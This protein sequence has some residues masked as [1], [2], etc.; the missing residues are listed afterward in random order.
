MTHLSRK[1]IEILR[2]PYLHR[3]LARKPRRR[4]LP[5]DGKNFLFILLN[6]IGD[7]IMA[8]P[9]WRML[10]SIRPQAKIELLC[11]RQIAALFNQDEALDAVHYFEADPD[12]WWSPR[13][14]H[15]IEAL[16]RKQNYEVILDFTESPL[17]ALA[18]ARNTAP[19]SI[20]F[21]RLCDRTSNLSRAYDC[22]VPYTDSEHIRDMM[23]HLASPWI[24]R[25]GISRPNPSLSVAEEVLDRATSALQD[26]SLRAGRFIVFHPGAKWSPKRWP[27]AHWSRLIRR[28]RD[29]TSWPLLLLGGKEDMP[30]VNDILQNSGDLPFPSLLG[31]TLSS[32]AAIIKLASLCVCNDSAAMHLAAAVGTPSIALFGP[33]SPSKSAPSPQE[34]CRVLYEEMFCSPCTLYYSRDRC[35]RGINFCMHALSPEKVFREMEKIIGNKY[36]GGS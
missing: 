13:N 28:L 19:P 36:S 25:R 26:R 32:A 6:A 4:P 11:R 22:S 27:I 3:A 16:W 34:G 30:L 9:V 2:T 15:R 31:E 8:Q 29:Q 23:M 12:E 24:P 5:H 14:V 20:G 7:A 21:Y 18:C 1:I 35:R 33:V 17:T 10:K